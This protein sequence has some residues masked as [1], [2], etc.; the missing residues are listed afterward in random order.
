MLYLNGK[1]HNF[2]RLQLIFQF[3]FSFIISLFLFLFLWHFVFVLLFLSILFKALLVF[4]KN[5]EKINNFVYLNCEQMNEV[6]HFIM[7]IIN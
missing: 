1:K 7:K 4:V 5:D 6:F 3:K 2:P